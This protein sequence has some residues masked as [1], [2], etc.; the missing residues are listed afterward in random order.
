MSKR[1]LRERLTALETAVANVLGEVGRF[2]FYRQT[3]EMTLQSQQRDINRILERLSPPELEA[4][5]KPAPELRDA[6]PEKQDASRRAGYPEPNRRLQPR[7]NSEKLVCL[8]VSK[9]VRQLAIARDTLALYADDK[10]WEGDR[11]SM[12]RN[13]AA[14]HA[15]GEMA[16]VEAASGYDTPAN[17]DVMTVEAFRDAV[18]AGSLMNCDGFG[19]PVRDGMADSRR[20]IRPSTADEIPEDATHVVWFNK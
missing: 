1:E 5:T 10:Y 12:L 19:Y 6:E 8:H 4:K 13:A 9:L 18:S 20:E 2:D 16:S 17:G 14:V 7:R 3:L 11:C 15:L